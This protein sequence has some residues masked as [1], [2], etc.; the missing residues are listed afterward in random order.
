MSAA[1]R[2][3]SARRP[4]HGD[5]VAGVRFAIDNYQLDI[6]GTCATCRATDRPPR[7]KRQHLAAVTPAMNASRN[8]SGSHV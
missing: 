7:G 4:D 3:G 8:R 5:V 6:V 2:N 1:L